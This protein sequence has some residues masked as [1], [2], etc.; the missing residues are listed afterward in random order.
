MSKGWIVVAV[1]ISIAA[2]VFGLDNG[3]ESFEKVWKLGFDQ[4]WL[5]GRAYQLGWSDAIDG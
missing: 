1:L 4:G 3:V 5:C 2:P